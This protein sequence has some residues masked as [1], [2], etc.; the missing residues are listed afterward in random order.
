M[1]KLMSIGWGCADPRRAVSFDSAAAA[2]VEGM[3]TTGRI[4][5]ATADIEA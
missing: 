5:A 1:R 3:S 2:L 4:P